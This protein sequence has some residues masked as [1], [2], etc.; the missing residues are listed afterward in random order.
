M[1]DED[2]VLGHGILGKFRG[3]ININSMLYFGSLFRVIACSTSFALVSLVI[4]VL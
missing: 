4:Y 1:L 3:N 2:G